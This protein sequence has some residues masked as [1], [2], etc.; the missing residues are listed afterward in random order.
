MLGEPDAATL[1]LLP[2]MTKLGPVDLCRRGLEV[3]WGMNG[4]IRAV[5]YACILRALVLFVRPFADHSLYSSA[6][7]ATALLNKGPRQ[8]F[9]CGSA[10]HVH[11]QLLD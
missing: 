10:F 5:L 2:P 4:R 11:R 1:Q 6:I 8:V 9:Y 7:T 3:R